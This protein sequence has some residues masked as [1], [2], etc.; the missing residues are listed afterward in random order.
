MDH[1][2]TAAASL[3][4]T[5]ARTESASWTI[6][7]VFS[8]S[9]IFIKNP[10]NVFNYESYVEPMAYLSWG[11]VVVFLLFTPPFLYFCFSYNP[12]PQDNISLAESFAAVFVTITMMGAP[13][14]PKNISARIVFLR[15]MNI[16][17]D[18]FNCFT[19]LWILAFS[20]VVTGLLVYY[21]W[22]AM[23]VT[24][25]A[26]RFEMQILQSKKWTQLFYTS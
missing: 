7:L 11:F 20:S 15:W 5:G 13:Y 17:N 14:K 10:T 12:N 26:T 21:H 6:P 8:H 18:S 23:L 16:N 19:N 3:I 25:L 9:S 24:H 22:E 1:I 2:I 4:Q